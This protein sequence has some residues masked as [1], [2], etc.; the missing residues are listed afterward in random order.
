MTATELL[1]QLAQGAAFSLKEIREAMAEIVG[2]E[3]YNTED[4]D[5][6]TDCLLRQSLFNVFLLLE[7]I[8]PLPNIRFLAW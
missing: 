5:A 1:S 2:K 6:M 4:L 3:F 7:I 8:Y